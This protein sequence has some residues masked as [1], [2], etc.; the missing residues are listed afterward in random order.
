MLSFAHTSKSHQIFSGIRRICSTLFLCEVISVFTAII[1]MRCS[2]LGLSG[3]NNSRELLPL[4]RRSSR[5]K[6]TV[7]GLSL[8]DGNLV[9]VI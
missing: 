7:T 8:M 5:H 3:L 6:T 4:K 1:I 9:Q 2:R